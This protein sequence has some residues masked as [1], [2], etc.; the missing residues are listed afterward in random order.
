MFL[1]ILLYALFASSF[2]LSKKAFLYISP[3]TCTGLR[4]I[5]AGVILLSF[6][7]YQAHKNKRKLST[8]N[9]KERK[10]LLYYTVSTAI[11]SNC[12][13]SWALI[14]ISAVKAAFYY[15][16]A[17]FVTAIIVFIFYREKLSKTEWLGISLGAIGTLPILFSHNNISNTANLANNVAN[18]FLSLN[19]NIGDIAIL[20]SVV[21]YAAGWILIKPIFKNSKIS[22]AKINGFAN[23]IGGGI[24]F[25]IGVLVENTEIPSLSNLYFWNLF[26]WNAILCIV[27]C[28]TLYMYLL[29]KYSPTFLALA[30]LVEPLFAAMYGYTHGID[31]TFLIALICVSLGLYIFHKDELKLEKLTNKKKS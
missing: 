1:V 23:L 30:S 11:L 31:H 20:C 3:L 13:S 6:A 4:G 28:Y 9:T 15:V 26:F 10:A 27:L 8:L 25:A 14:H 21:T 2:P 18:N 22:P 17:P 29:K 5:F 7:F 16:L 24:V 12:L 19:I